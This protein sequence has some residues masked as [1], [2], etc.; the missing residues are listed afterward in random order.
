M[1]GVCPSCDLFLQT[2]QTCTFRPILTQF[3]ACE[4]VKDLPTIDCLSQWSEGCFHI[5]DWWS[6]IIVQ[7]AIQWLFQLR[8]HRSQ[9]VQLFSFLRKDLNHCFL[10]RQRCFSPFQL[11]QTDSQTE[12][13]S[14]VFQSVHCKLQLQCVFFR[15]QDFPKDKVTNLSF[16]IRWSLSHSFHKVQTISVNL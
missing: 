9:E 8:C 16:C 12:L 5:C 14:N 6:N 1:Q 3:V 7:K 2:S 15:I 10:Y 13:Q 4:E 11:R